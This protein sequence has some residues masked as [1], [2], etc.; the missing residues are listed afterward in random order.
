M[1]VCK[2]EV[3]IEEVNKDYTPAGSLAKERS[4]SSHSDEDKASRGSVAQFRAVFV[5]EF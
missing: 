3:E 4:V 2:W 5:C 1:V